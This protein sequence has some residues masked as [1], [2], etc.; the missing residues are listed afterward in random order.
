MLLQVG[1]L[2]AIG[3]G[4]MEPS[5]IPKLLNQGSSQLPGEGWQLCLSEE[6]G[7]VA[8][9]FHLQWSTADHEMTS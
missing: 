4:L 1:A 2:V 6:K 7:P 5:V 8:H 9:T 3:T